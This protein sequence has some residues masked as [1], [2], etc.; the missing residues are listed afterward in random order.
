MTNRSVTGSTMLVFGFSIELAG[1]YYLPV[2]KLFPVF[3][4]TGP[5]WSPV[6]GWT[7]QSGP[8][9]K[10]MLKHFLSYFILTIKYGDLNH[11][12]PIHYL[13]EIKEII[14]N[15]QHKENVIRPREIG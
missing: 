7:G 10:T 12:H 8:V 11:K 4:I 2:F 9:F 15:Y 1:L 5:D 3:T 13:N 6:P 14:Y